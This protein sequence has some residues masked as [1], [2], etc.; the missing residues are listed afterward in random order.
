MNRVEAIDRYD[1][2]INRHN[3]LRGQSLP[4]SYEVQV[5]VD[6]IKRIKRKKSPIVLDLACGVGKT[7]IAIE[8]ERVRVV[9]LDISLKSL[10]KG[11]GSKVRAVF[12]NVPFRDE[13]FDAVHFKDALV[14]V[15]NHEDLFKQIFRIL[16]PGGKF[17]IATTEFDTFNPSF[18]VRSKKTGRL[19]MIGF[20]DEDEFI[21]KME[22]IKKRG[23]M[24][25]MEIYPPYYPVSRTNLRNELLIAGFEIDSISTWRPEYEEK[26]WFLEPTERVVYSSMKPKS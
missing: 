20:A 7:S 22:K 9:G 21:L 16:K 1:F 14:H 24:K 8:N 2:S 19:R 26:D 4:K 5:L 18:T 23:R 3:P 25:E 12:E 17:L 6:F 11:L 15:P 10:K 13:S